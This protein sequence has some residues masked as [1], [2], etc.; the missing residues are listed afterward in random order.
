MPIKVPGSRAGSSIHLTGL[1]VGI[2]G[3]SGR[4]VLVNLN[5]TPMIDMFVILLVFL[6]MVFSASGEIL[7]A[8]K[9]IQLPKAFASKPLVRVPI[10]GISMDVI[11]FEGLK[12]M[13]TNGVSEKNYPDLKLPELTKVLK[14][15]RAAFLREHPMPVD[16]DKAIKWFE[17]SKQII[18][19][20]DN[21][22]P[23]EVIRMVMTT[24]AHEGYSAINFAVVPGK[25]ALDDVIK[26]AT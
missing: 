20:A 26:N 22:V 14:S 24:A 9:D 15:S 18:I 4:N 2:K 1:K 16:R 23:F 12:V 21:G 10:I 5:L 8:Q 19:Q 25:S 6:L 11:L 7:F 13:F 3:G 17:N